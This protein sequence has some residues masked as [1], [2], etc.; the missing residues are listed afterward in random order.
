MADNEELEERQGEEAAEVTEAAAETAEASPAAGEAGEEAAPEGD[1]PG[2]GEEKT[3]EPAKPE[4]KKS[5]VKG[6]G[7]K[8]LMTILYLLL[9]VV[10]LV[11]VYLWFLY[12]TLAP[13][14]KE[15]DGQQQPQ[16]TVMSSS[17]AN[18][19]GS[20]RPSDWPEAEAVYS[21]IPPEQFGEA[22]EDDQGESTEPTEP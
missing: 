6:L 16:Q 9:V 21:G 11:E 15:E 19:D 2:E 12:D 3:E 8:I 17:Y 14:G 20:F 10:V 5:R 13:A 1:A 18:W 4:E 7:R 22:E